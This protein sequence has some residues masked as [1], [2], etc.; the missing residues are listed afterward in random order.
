MKTI[1]ITGSTRGIGYGLADSFLTL[2]CAVTVSGRSQEGVDRAVAT[3]SAKHE[4]G[5]VMGHPCD[6]T[7]YEQ[8][9]ALWDAA[10][11][12]WG[13]VDVW[14]NNAGGTHPQAKFWE[15]K[16]ERIKVVVDAN[17]LG[18]MYGSKVALR[19]MLAQ[20]SGSLYSMEGMGSTGRK[21]D[22]LAVYGTTKCG[23]RYLN[24]S[25]A[26]E[27]RETPVLVG[28][29][30]PGMVVTDFLTGQYKDRPEDWERAKPIL[31]ILADRVETVTPWLAQKALANEKNGVCISWISRRKIMWRFLTARFCKR[32]LFE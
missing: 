10:Q 23:L 27:V 21:M 28:A 11:A 24:E 14:I 31:N 6:V 12:H 17:L 13:Q 30:R 8:V 32:D 19:G 1:V 29:L 15:L 25:L 18:A 4:A 9:Q 7:H 26:H 5:R 16:P 22:G 20:G 3:L 2:D